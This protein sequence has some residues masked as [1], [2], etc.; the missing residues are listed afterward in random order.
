MTTGNS[1]HQR[2][3]SNIHMRLK[4]K[5]ELEITNQSLKLLGKLS[6]PFFMY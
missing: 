1:E 6:I 2:Q 3:H 5:D 4:Y